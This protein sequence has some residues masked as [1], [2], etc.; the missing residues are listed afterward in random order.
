MK[1]KQTNKK[2]KS[3]NEFKVCPFKVN[4]NNDKNNSNYCMFILIPI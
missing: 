2:Q 3:D 4:E 1:G